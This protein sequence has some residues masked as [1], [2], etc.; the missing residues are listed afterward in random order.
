MDG[1]SPTECSCGASNFERVIV[2]RPNGDA[3]RTDFVACI[4]CR[5]MYFDPEAKAEPPAGWVN[6]MPAVDPR[7]FP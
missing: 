5:V 6:L 1:R 7:K 2:R 3:Y 4:E